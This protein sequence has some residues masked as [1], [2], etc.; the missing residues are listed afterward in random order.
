MVFFYSCTFV[1]ET[2]M[3]FGLLLVL[4]LVSRV[5]AFGNTNALIP[6]LVDLRDKCP[7]SSFLP[8]LECCLAASKLNKAGVFCNPLVRTVLGQTDGVYV[9][10]NI[11]YNLLRWCG[12]WSMAP[13]WWYALAVHEA[14][15]LPIDCVPFQGKTYFGG[16]FAL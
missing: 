6:L 4:S 12:F 5:S 8:G 11:Q 15:F 13:T 16:W 9:L 2:Q 7:V 10:D 3:W 14:N 1:F